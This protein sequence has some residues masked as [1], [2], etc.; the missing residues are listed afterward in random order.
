MPAETAEPMRA[1]EL[2]R[3]LHHHIPLSR[4]LGVRVEH[5]RPESVCLVAPLGPNLNHHQTA[6]GGSVA[7]LAILAGW[8]WLQSRLESRSP[9]PRLVIQ[10]Q[11]VEYLAP[12]DAA[13]EAICPAPPDAEWRRFLRA[14]DA[15]G[16]DRL[17]VAVQVL[18]RGEV[19]ARFRGRY[20]AV[21]DAAGAS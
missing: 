9:S 11:T 14:L 18:C 10:Q 4:A 2:E 16:R 3:F 21:T 6:F 12:V 7:S 13:F 17:E 8:S 20:V 19:A 5:V 15:R 1:A